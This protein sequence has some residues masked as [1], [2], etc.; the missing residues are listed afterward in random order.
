[1]LARNPIAKRESR[2]A[3]EMRSPADRKLDFETYTPALTEA[4]AVQEASRCLG[5]GCGVG[6]GLCFQICTHFAVSRDGCDAFQMDKEKCVACG[7]C[8]R[9]CPNQNIEMVREEGLVPSVT[10]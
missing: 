1:V 3:L 2:V 5:C 6:C 10:T 7:M 9:R 8:F 4:Q